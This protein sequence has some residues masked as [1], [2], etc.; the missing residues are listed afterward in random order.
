MAQLAFSVHAAV[1]VDERCSMPAEDVA[2]ILEYRLCVLLGQRNGKDHYL[3]WDE[4][5]YQPFVAIVCAQDQYVITVLPVDYHE[6][7]A[8]NITPAAIKSARN[9]VSRSYAPT[10]KHPKAETKESPA[11]LPALRKIRMSVYP[12]NP[13]HPAISLDAP[14]ASAVPGIERQPWPEVTVATVRAVLAPHRDQV[15][16]GDTLAVLFKAGDP[17]I[18]FVITADLLTQL[19]SSAPATT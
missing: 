10:G 7:V 6:N 16:A 12:G 11:S 18:P 3:F 15:E 5:A 17:R 4:Q 1:R 19:D 8:W 14:W 13:K 2:Q 9:K